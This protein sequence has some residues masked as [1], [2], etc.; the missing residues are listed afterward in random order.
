M[1]RRNEG[2]GSK[3]LYFVTGNRGKFIEAEDILRQFGFRLRQEDL[4]L[5]EPQSDS[6]EYVAKRTA[7]SAFEALKRPLFLE[8]AGLFI[9]TLNGFPGVFSSYVYSSIGVEG[10]LRLMRDVGERR[11]RFKSCVAFV[12]SAIYPKPKL[13]MGEVE[14]H[15]SRSAK[16][17]QGFG[18]D[19]IFVPSGFSKTFAQ[20]STSQKNR[21]SHRSKAIRAIGSFL[22]RNPSLLG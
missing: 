12:S 6:L 14:G 4:E 17:E 20:M 16:G 19:P 18:F 15:I 13:F 22:S 7:L 9:D 3:L 21:L 5:D 8:D 2:R 11:A 10:I 1:P